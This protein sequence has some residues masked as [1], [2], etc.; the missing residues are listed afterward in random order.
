MSAYYSFFS[1]RSQTANPQVVSLSL[2][3]APWDPTK[4]LVHPAGYPIEAPPLYSVVTCKE[5]A[6]NVVVLRGW[7]AGPWDMVGDARL[8]SLSS[9]SRITLHGQ[10]IDMRLSQ[11]SGHFSFQTSSTG[12][13][14][15]KA[16]MLS[17]KNL[18]L[19]D[20]SGRK[21]AT[22]QPSGTSGEK[23]LEVSVS[24]DSR[25][26]E[27]V[28]LSGMTAKAMNKAENETAVEILGSILGA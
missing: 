16:N 27:L 20:A 12:R 26:L 24:H 3:P 8:P 28:L 10:P 14:K 1:T 22:I 6:P 4:V 15:W 11:V 2:R 21:M 23:K 19:H 25:F 9:K 17:G 7:G 13:L 18:E 5:Q